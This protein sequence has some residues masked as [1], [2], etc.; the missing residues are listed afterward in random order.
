MSVPFSRGAAALALLASF[1]ILACGA[2]TTPPAASRQAA[3]TTT[4]TD[5]ST[6]DVAAAGKPLCLA[7][8]IGPTFYYRLDL[9]G[10]YVVA[11]QEDI[12]GPLLRD[13]GRWSQPSAGRLLF[14]ST[15]RVHEISIGDL[16]VADAKD[17]DAEREYP[18][19]RASTRAFLDAHPGSTFA[20]SE[21][22]GIGRP[23]VV[24]DAPSV[25]RADVERLLVELDRR[26]SPA[27]RHQYG[28]VIGTRGDAVIA[29]LDDEGPK[30]LATARAR[31]AAEEREGILV[32][33]DPAR[34]AALASLSDATGR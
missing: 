15:D 5:A 18:R 24:G 14:E 25:P 17:A 13:H 3:P 20:A 34:C 23:L 31:L 6:F 16:E 22:K 28:G 32:Q 10:Q 9:S 7:M 26:I 27:T 11:R 8:G 12:G 30:D 4:R 2:S 19:L 1:G 33:V 29:C 21:V